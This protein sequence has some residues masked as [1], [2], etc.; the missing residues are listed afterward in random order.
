MA[1]IT[2]NLWYRLSEELYLKNRE[3]LTCV[4]KPYV[5]RLLAALCRHCQIEPDHVS[6]YTQTLGTLWEFTFKGCGQLGSAGNQWKSISVAIIS[7][8]AT[9][10]L[11]ATGTNSHNRALLVIQSDH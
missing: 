6:T 5:E 8:S 4:F 1:D 11:C 10:I 3:E 7:Y 9:G 2:F